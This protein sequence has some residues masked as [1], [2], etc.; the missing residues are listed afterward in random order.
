MRH[1]ATPPA[2]LPALISTIALLGIVACTRCASVSPP[3]SSRGPAPPPDTLT[4]TCKAVDVRGGT[5][6]VITGVGQALRVESFSVGSTCEILV[7]G[8][9]GRIE[10]LEPGKIVRIRF[11]KT[12]DRNVAEA[13]EAVPVKGSEGAK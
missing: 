12:P 8:G 9:E 7:R 13:I 11:R 1:R 2:P 5:V 10:D 3:E 6:T 4:A